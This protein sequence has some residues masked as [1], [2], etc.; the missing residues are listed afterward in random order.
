[1]FALLLSINNEKRCGVE[2]ISTITQISEQSKTTTA[3][4]SC[5]QTPLLG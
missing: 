5:S 3:L 2:T 4:Y 1:M